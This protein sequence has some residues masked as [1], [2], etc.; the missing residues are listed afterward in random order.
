MYIK[1]LWRYPVKSMAGERLKEVSVNELDRPYTRIIRPLRL[2]STGKIKP[3][4]DHDPGDIVQRMAVP[5]AQLVGPEQQRVVKQAAIAA[6][7]GRFGQSLSAVS[8]RRCLLTTDQGFGR[9]AG[10][11]VLS[12][13]LIVL[14]C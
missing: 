14:R 3:V 8:R 7:L 12:G 1:E 2:R 4:A 9:C 5:L 10:F 6:R 13:R 11:A